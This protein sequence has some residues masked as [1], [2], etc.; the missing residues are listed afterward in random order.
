MLL[1]LALLGAA[2]S[3]PFVVAEGSDDGPQPGQVAPEPG[4]RSWIRE[5]G[6]PGRTLADLRG[7]VVV[8]HSF[9]WNCSTCLK[10]GIPLAVDL[11]EANE[12]FGLTVL[13]VT[14]PAK[15]E[16]TVRV[17]DEFGVRH[18]VALENP[19]NNENPYIDISKN[20]ITY[21]FVIGRSGD[22]VWRGDPSRD[23]DECLDAV[24]RA[25]QASPG[26]ELDRPLQPDLAEAVAEYFA[27][28]CRK[29]R[30][31]A[32]KLAGI[33]S[34]RRKEESRRIAEDAEHL[35]ERIDALGTRLFEDLKQALDAG[36]ALGFVRARNELR[37]CLG[38]EASEDSAPLFEKARADEEFATAVSLAEEW[39]E[40]ERSRPP[41]FPVRSTKECEKFAKRLARFADRTS[42]SPYRH[43]A[44]AWLE[45][46]G[47][48]HD[49]R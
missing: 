29:A 3:I 48:Y 19:F 44:S 5:S 22:L 14:T 39:L 30:N 21:M 7:R 2:A 45:R 23:L 1:G 16:E 12:D 40:I 35:L 8:L 43:T 25:L 27:G 10:V 11:F 36:D 18:P 17:L 4:L 38:K 9:A 33:H 32:E 15:R 13:S 49:R 41:L 34:G 37:E 24:S 47:E 28:D 42:E 26:R 6:P 20:P 46:Y 31:R